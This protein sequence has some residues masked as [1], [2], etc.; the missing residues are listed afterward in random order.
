MAAADIHYFVQ[1][2]VN[3]QETELVIKTA[4]GDAGDCQS[5]NRKK[6]C[7]RA[8]K[9]D[10]I[11]VSFLLAGDTK[12]SETD[13]EKWKLK[14]V[15]LAKDASSKP[16]TWGGFTAGGDVDKDLNF[17]NPGTGVLNTVGTNSD[18]QITIEN[19]NQSKFVVWYKVAAVC[20]DSSGATLKTITTD[21]RM[22]NGGRN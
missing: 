8:N 18:R 14:D 21:P 9:F 3:A 15:T 10:Q 19:R 6:G 11:K 17:K 13:G 2:K 4:K 5:S 22:E 20:V 16:T 7:I 1:M 12:C